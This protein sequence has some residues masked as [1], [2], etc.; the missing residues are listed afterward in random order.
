MK[1]KVVV[2]YVDLCVC[3]CIYRR[4]LLEFLNS[5][6]MRRR[7]RRSV[8]LTY[9]LL[10]YPPIHLAVSCLFVQYAYLM[11]LCSHSHSH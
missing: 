10:A 9:H 4:R 3:V 7:L 6:C 8:L 2:M 1:E 11:C 5:S